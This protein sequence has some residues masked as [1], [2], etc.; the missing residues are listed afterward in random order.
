VSVRELFTELAELLLRKHRDYGPKNIANSPG[1]PLN[2]I[3]VRL[4]DKTARID[5]LLDHNLE[6]QNE[7]LE[8]AFVD[9]SVYNAIAVLVMRGQW[10]LA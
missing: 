7:P 8:D 2:G 9:S 6:A 3:R 10:P 1:G 4:Y 5:H